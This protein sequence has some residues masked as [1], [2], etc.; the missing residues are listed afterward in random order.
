[1]YCNI[2]NS[3]TATFDQFNVPLLKKSINLFQNK[4]SKLTDV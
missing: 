4:K 1:M 2:I 3:F